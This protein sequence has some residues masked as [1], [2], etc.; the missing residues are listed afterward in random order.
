MFIFIGGALD[1]LELGYGYVMY[2]GFNYIFMLLFTFTELHEPYLAVQTYGYAKLD[3]NWDER[4]DS[5]QILGRKLTPSNRPSHDSTAD[6]DFQ[7]WIVVLDMVEAFYQNVPEINYG[8]YP[9]LP[10]SWHLVCASLGKKWVFKIWKVKTPWTQEIMLSH[11]L[12]EYNLE[13]SWV[14]LSFGARVADL[15]KIG[16]L[17]WLTY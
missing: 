11:L 10:W 14:K 5:K 3:E 2:M 9:N 15:C 4:K 17:A 7:R 6:S 13:K 16:A 12:W 8:F 1:C